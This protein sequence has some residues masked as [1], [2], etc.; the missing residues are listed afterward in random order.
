MPGGPA[1][2]EKGEE[3]LRPLASSASNRWAVL[4]DAGEFGTAAVDATSDCIQADTSP[5]YCISATIYNIRQC[6]G[7][8]IGSGLLMP[9]LAGNERA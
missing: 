5:D 4:R 2:T 9:E 8:I 1:F 3:P 6:F 7:F